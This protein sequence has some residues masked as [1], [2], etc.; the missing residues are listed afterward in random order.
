MPK[1]VN[2]YGGQNSCLVNAQTVFRGALAVKNKHQ[3]TLSLVLERAGKQSSI[4]TVYKGF[5]YG[6]G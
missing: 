4:L 3:G 2:M 5:G 1:L 6:V